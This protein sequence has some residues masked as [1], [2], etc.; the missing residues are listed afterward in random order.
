V[1]LYFT[2]P[3]PGTNIER[4]V[5]VSPLIALRLFAT[6]HSS[7]K[8]VITLPLCS[9]GTVISILRIAEPVH[10]H[11]RH[12][13]RKSTGAIAGVGYEKFLTDPLRS[14]TTRFQGNVY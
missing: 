13:K 10:R 12:Q 1:L 9:S 2:S 6:P 3:A 7:C 5:D 8:K 11:V 4:R 14:T